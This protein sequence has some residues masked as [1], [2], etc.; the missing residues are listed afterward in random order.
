MLFVLS[1]PFIAFAYAQYLLDATGSENQK[2]RVEIPV[3]ANAAAISERLKDA[4]VIRSPLA[5]QAVARVLGDS[6]NMKAGVYDIPRSLG[7]FEIVDLLVR[8]DALSVWV[9]IPEGSTARDVAERLEASKLGNS[10]SFLRLMQHSPRRFGSE[11]PAPWGGCEGYLF[12]DT[13]RLDTNVAPADVVKKML[14]T[15]QTKAYEPRRRKFASSRYGTAKTMIIASMIEKEAKV[16]EDRPLIASVIYNR[17]RRRMR[18]QIDATVLYALGGH[19]PLVT[20]KDLK[21][22]SPYNTYRVRGLP[23]GPICSPGEASIDAALDPATTRYLFY[24]ARPDGS[25]IF[26][27]SAAEHDAAVRE[28]RGE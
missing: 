4:G 13:Y 20:L 9:P 27:K 26:T 10:N 7:V 21:V 22:K 1:L 17:L 19:K 8:G 12:P 6:R 11:A 15:W 2:V 24:V 3:G 28:V 14:E 23:P 18:L 25:H 5:F 16:A